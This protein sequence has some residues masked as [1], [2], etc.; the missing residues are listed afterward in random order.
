LPVAGELEIALVSRRRKLLERL[1][2]WAR[3]RGPPFDARPEPTP[4]QV[5]RAAESAMPAAAEWASAIERA[6]FDRDD[7][8]ARV[9][10][11]VMELD[12]DKPPKPRR[13]R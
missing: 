3:R 7:V 2:Q 11:E 10:N 4:A 6:A 12:P 1:V 8:D 5:R 13:E 9:E